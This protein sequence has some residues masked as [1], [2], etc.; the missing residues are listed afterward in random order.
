MTLSGNRIQ[1]I[2][3][4]FE[5]INRISTDRTKSNVGL[6]VAAIEWNGC[7]AFVVDRSI[8]HKK[9]ISEQ[10]A[11]SLLFIFSLSMHLFSK[12]THMHTDLRTQH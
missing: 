5:T 2:T 3:I 8:A 7:P 1:A 6:T 10:R 9:L 11:D 12:Q 4:S